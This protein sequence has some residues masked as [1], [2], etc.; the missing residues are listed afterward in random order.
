MPQK[1]LLSGV[2]PTGEIHVGNYFG[3][4]KQFLELQNSY[5]SY[6]FI[7]DLHA[8]N[9]IHN[10]E[11]LSRSIQEVAKAYLAVGLN[12]N[13]VCLFRQSRV[14]AHSELCWIL[15]SITPMGLIER[16]HAYK[17]AQTKGKPINM[18]LFDYPV[19]MAADILAYQADVVPVGYDQQQHLEMTVDIAKRFNH[20]FGPTFN[21]PQGLV[22]KETG[23]VPG[24]DGQ[25]M[26]KSYH[27]VIGLF[28]PPEVIAK[29]VMSMVTDSRGT[30]EPKDPVS[31][32]VFALHRLFSTV[33]LEELNERYRNGG[34]S[35]RES[36]EILIQ[37]MSAFL[38][39]FRERK[40]GLDK[41]SEYIKEI[42]VEGSRKASQVANET[43]DLVRQRTGLA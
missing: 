42:L 3:A 21:L 10:P 39:D 34:I 14:A 7:A 6:V 1:R 30:N 43:M 16:A 13:K 31:D 29:K 33:Q 11:D 28:D 35:Y 23:V 22:L 36:K 5:E 12:P 8:L 38:R 26:S 18:G 17:D 9:Q 2:K 32:N 27:N 4:I 19:L 25:K 24:L 37:N 15:N 41:K 20:L 40:V